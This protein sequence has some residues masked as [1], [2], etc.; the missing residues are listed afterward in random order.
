MSGLL[1]ATTR[2]RP[3]PRRCRTCGSGPARSARR[4][5]SARAG[6]VAVHDPGFLDRLDVLER[7]RRRRDGAGEHAR[8]RPTVRGPVCRAEAQEALIAEG[9]PAVRD[10]RVSTSPTSTAW[11]G[12]STRS[13]Q[14]CFFALA[15]CAPARRG[16]RPGQAVGA[17]DLG[18]ARPRDRAP[19]RRRDRRR[20]GRAPRGRRP[21]AVDTA[22][23]SPTG[24]TR[25]RTRL[26]AARH[27][28]P[29]RRSRR[30]AARERVPARRDLADRHEPVREAGHRPRD[31]DLGTRPV[32]AVQPVLDDLSR[33]PPSS[34]RCSN[35]ATPRARPRAFRSVPEG[36][37]PEFEGLDYIGAGRA[38][39][40][41][42]LRAL[43]R[44]LPRQGPHPAET[45][46]DQHAARRRAPRPRTRGVRR[47]SSQIPDVRPHPH[48]RPRPHPGAAPRHGSSSPGRAPA[49][50]RP[51]TSG[52]LTQLFGDRLVIANAT[53]CSS[54]YG[55]NLPTTPYTTGP[56]GRGPAWSNSLFEDN[57]EFGFGLRLGARRPGT[58][59]PACCW[60]AARPSCPTRLV[61]AL[62]RRVRHRR[63]VDHRG[64]VS[65]SRSC[66]TASPSSTVRTPRSSTGS[67]ITSSPARC[68]LVGG[69]GWAYDIGYGGL[70]HVLASNREGQ[71][72]G[73]RHRGVLQHRRPAVQGHPA[74]RGREVRVRGQ[75]DPQEGPRA[76]RH[77]LRARLRRQRRHAG[78]QP[79]HPHGDA[80]S[81]EPIR[82][83]RSSSRTAPA[84]RTATTSS[85]PPPS[86]PAP[87]T[88]APG[89]STATTPDGSPPANRRWSSTPTPPRCRSAST[90]SRRPG[91]G[92]SSSATP[93][94]TSASFT[95]RSR[96]SD[97]RHALYEQ[98]AQIRLPAP[99]G[100]RWLISPPPG[101]ASTSRSP[102]VVGASP[103]CDDLAAARRLVDAGAG[104]VV[105]RSVF[106]EQTRRRPAR[107][108]PLHRQPRRQRRRSP[109]VP[110]RHRRLRRRRR[111]PPS[112]SSPS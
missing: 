103:L 100:F 49:A 84:S 1:R 55:G 56:D 60:T 50:A 52:L 44:G 15:G 27:P 65:T 66:A 40:L 18:Q 5:R 11:V 105:L 4:T 61:D 90:W 79:S 76:P 63:R 59:G 46:G 48:P 9:V 96:R 80:R 2:R 30:P 12:G 26:R 42:R 47:S 57:A 86:R 91:S 98:L 110:P 39:R 68:G 82:A 112:P 45:Q 109:V 13:C 64:G 73:A 71:R 14:T 67:P 95:R 81:R 89:R 102:F 8:S 75:G 7:G 69:D 6:F 99:G 70:D 10:R 101:S 83:R 25:R 21:G 34:P 43:R 51:R 28:P 104:A 108:P 32:R 97:E 54:I 85:T 74:R 22:R 35:P 20:A 94:A 24:G 111:R 106:E 53:G 29:P 107:R 88:A 93:T 77:E 62:T 23:Q 58:P 78:P 31:P 92:W 17:D 3:G 38:R 41:H 19:Q 36:F 33:T 16:D 87:S 37:T 72:A